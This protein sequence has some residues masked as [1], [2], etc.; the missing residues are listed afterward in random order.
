MPITASWFRAAAAALVLTATSVTSARADVI[1]DWNAKA[2]VILLEKLQRPP[3]A[4]RAMA[5]KHV[6]MFEAVNAIDRRYAPYRLKLTADKDLPKDAAA[7]AAAYAVLTTLYPDQ[8]PGLD[9]AL[10]TLLAGVPDGEPKTKAIELGKRA[11]AEIVALRADDG[12]NAKEATAR[13]PA[14]ASISRRRF[15]SVRPTAR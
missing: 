1:S 4:A 3:T 10:R 2:E 14:P 11:A 6:A 5:M 7:A 8:Q 9:T 12:I 15:R 13:S